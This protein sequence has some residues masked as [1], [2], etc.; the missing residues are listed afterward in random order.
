MNWNWSEPETTVDLTKPNRIAAKCVRPP[1]Y[2][3]IANAQHSE[4]FVDQSRRCSADAVAATH[5]RQLI[6]ITHA[7]LCVVLVLFYYF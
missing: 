6:Y 3:E 4:Q 5:R 1:E 7:S 2:I